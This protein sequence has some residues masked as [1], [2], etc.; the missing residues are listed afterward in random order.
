MH[1]ELQKAIIEESKNYTWM[2]LWKRN[3]GKVKRG[4]FYVHY[5]IIGGA[6][7]EGIVL[8]NYGY[9]V[10]IEIEVKTGSAR[11]TDKQKKFQA[12]V[13]KLGA[14]YYIA[15]NIKETIEWCQEIRRGG[16]CRDVN[17]DK[18]SVPKSFIRRTGKTRRKKI[19]GNPG[20]KTGKRKKEN[21]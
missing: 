3:T 6:D 8:N 4:F 15:N 18:H 10:H 7:I 9:G 12:I 14:Y 16:R 1:D 11:Q 21:I 19:Q 13:E 20:G 17:G 2:K 5:G